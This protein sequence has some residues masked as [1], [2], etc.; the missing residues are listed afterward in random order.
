[1]MGLVSTKYF[2]RILESY[3]IIAHFVQWLIGFNSIWPEIKVFY[4]ICEALNVSS[5]DEEGLFVHPFIW[6]R[7][8]KKRDLFN[9]SFS[10]QLRAVV[11]SVM[12]PVMT[13]I[14]WSNLM[15]VMAAQPQTRCRSHQTIHF[16]IDQNFKRFYT[17][18]NLELI[19]SCASSPRPW[20]IQCQ[21]DLMLIVNCLQSCTW[22]SWLRVQ[23][24]PSVLA[25]G[26]ERPISE[27]SLIKRCK[28]EF[29][30]F[31]LA[32]WPV[33]AVWMIQIC[34]KVS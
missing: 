24:P 26:P 8:C 33:T 17:R 7:N 25:P 18:F 10:S 28:F 6:Q 9:G 3:K 34:E 22:L 31:Q 21:C 30:V 32:F 15:A 1:M 12:A 14:Q 29:I 13:L 5:W 20:V 23:I 4:F 2:I 16:N 11:G 19:A 27:K